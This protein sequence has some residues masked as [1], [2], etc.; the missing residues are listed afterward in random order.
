M[1]ERFGVN[2][3][4]SGN[5]KRR[6]SLEASGVEKSLHYTESYFIF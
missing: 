2:P 1:F 6:I 3:L 5:N 4:G